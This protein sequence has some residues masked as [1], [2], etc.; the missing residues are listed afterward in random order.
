M[1]K[2]QDGTIILS[3]IATMTEELNVAKARSIDV[4]DA[5]PAPAV[6]CEHT[7][8]RG[9]P[10]V[11]IDQAVLAQSL[12][13]RGTTALGNLFGCSARTVRRRALDAGLAQSGQPVYVETEDE[14]GNTVRFYSGR[15][16]TS[17]NDVPD[18]QLDLMMTQ[19][20]TAMP[21]IGRRLIMGRLTFL[22]HPVPRSRVEASYNRVH[23]PTTNSFNRQRIT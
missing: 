11:V 4:P 10:K 23:G 7:G 3:S 8:K 22:G 14:E 13:Y 18:D 9:R 15:Q 2:P 16:S 21:T 17:A 20:L 5:P 6:Y 1:L 12:Q 19:I